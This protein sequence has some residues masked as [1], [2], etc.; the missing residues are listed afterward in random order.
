ML[1]QENQDI[2]L[3]IARASISNGLRQG[4]PLPIRLEDY[5]PV[6]QA[7]RASFVTLQIN[8][9]LRGCIGSLEAVR[10]LVED[11][12]ENAFAAAFRDPRFP[13]VSDREFDQLDY[14]ISILSPSK[15]LEF[16][17]ENDLLK[18]LRP[19]IDGLILEER[20]QRGT[21]LPSVWESLPSPRQFL[22]QLKVKAG[23]PAD[24]WSDSIKVE[25]YTVE[26]VKSTP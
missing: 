1:A 17:S 4:Q 9:Q 18:K 23:L 6:L 2:L 7:P 22:A 12:A 8:D 16:E 5:P 21:F 24:Y 3:N 15:P 25:R 26:D 11:V 19:G 14:H 13:P 10:P 20:G